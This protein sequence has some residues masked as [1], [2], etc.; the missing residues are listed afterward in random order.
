MS[1]LPAI[2]ASARATSSKVTLEAF[3]PLA[4]SRR[5]FSFRPP[6]QSQAQ[7]DVS[8]RI[9][10]LMRESA[11]PV[12]LITTFL[13]SSRLIHG[14]T[15]SSFSSISQRPDLVCF[16]M[17]TPSKLADALASHV[18]E[19]GKD[20]ET[21]EADMVIN[22]L[23]ESQAALA[24]AYARPGTPPF[25]YA[26]EGEGEGRLEGDLHP[27]EEAGLVSMDGEGLPVVQGSI[28]ALGC[29]VVDTIELDRYSNK[30]EQ[31]KQGSKSKLYIARV[32]NVHLPDTTSQTPLIY[33]RQKFVTTTT[34]LSTDTN[35]Q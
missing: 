22:V 12:A 33:H 23:S 30:H 2:A 3:R 29:Q 31:D 7:Q 35:T 24:D 13:P 17:K 18:A 32:I 20:E 1:L 15:L 11:Q 16:A 26:L 6:L 28:G 10:H 5:R 8:S 14:A 19:R 9:R 21:G 34:D 25:E 4:C 27:L